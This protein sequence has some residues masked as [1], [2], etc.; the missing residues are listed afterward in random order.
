[1]GAPG[2]SVQSLCRVWFLCCSFGVHSVETG[3]RP[4]AHVVWFPTG[5]GGW[6]K[7]FLEQSNFNVLVHACHIERVVRKFVKGIA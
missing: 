4:S 5:G 7:N 6:E 3:Q 2:N 1:M